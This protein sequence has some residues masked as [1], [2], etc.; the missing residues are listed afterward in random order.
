MPLSEFSLYAMRDETA[1]HKFA[2]RVSNLQARM[3]KSLNELYAARG[4]TLTLPLNEL[5]WT[6]I[7][8]GL[9]MT[10]QFFIH[11]EGLPEGT[12]ERA[13]EQVLK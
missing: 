8:L 11:L 2:S 6:I 12:H 7:A 1:R 3:E 10:I 13:L 5:P 4:K 9:G